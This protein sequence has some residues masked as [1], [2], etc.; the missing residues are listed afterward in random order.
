MLCFALSQ[1]HLCLKGIR[2]QSTPRFIMQA[3]V[4]YVTNK[5]FAKQTKVEHAPFS[6]LTTLN[7]ALVAKAQVTVC[8]V[9]DK[10]NGQ[11]A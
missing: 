8:I 5:G 9:A 10:Q 7:C 2:Q 1:S 6:M 4:L 3:C 11:L